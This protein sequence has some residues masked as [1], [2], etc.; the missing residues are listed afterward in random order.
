MKYYYDVHIHS[1]LSPCADLLMTPNNI[2]NM[3]YLKGLN[4]I[5]ITD[6]NSLKQLP[7]LDEIAKS[8]SFL[9]VYGVEVCVREEVH[10]LCYFKT[11]SEAMR[12]DKELEKHID[13]SIPEKVGTPVLTDHEDFAVSSLPYSLSSPLD[14]GLA[15]L[16]KILEDYDHL[17]FF[18]HIERPKYGGLPYVH[19][20]SMNGIEMSSSCTEQFKKENGLEKFP[21]LHNSDA[22][23]LMDIMERTEHNV[24]EL[25]RLDIDCFFQAFRS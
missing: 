18:A 15:D 4:I 3:V 1:V 16:C 13:K 25:E 11:L 21:I 19:T 12:F 14:L 20:V 2:L 22:H 6:H 24:I 5:A 7:V 9:F 8:Y 10:V 17:R 23:Q